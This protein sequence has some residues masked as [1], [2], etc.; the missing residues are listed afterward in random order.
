LIAK[1]VLFYRGIKFTIINGKTQTV[2][3]YRMLPINLNKNIN[4]M[5][6]IGTVRFEFG[7][8]QYELYESSRESL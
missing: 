2:P 6:D 4:K 7:N 1:F 5:F 3:N 8:V